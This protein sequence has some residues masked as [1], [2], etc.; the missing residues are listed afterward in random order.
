VC[1]AL[2]LVAAGA[3]AATPEEM[4][5]R[6]N[7]AYERGEYEQAAEDYRAVLRYRI[8]DPVVEYNLGNAE[9]KL[10][11]LGRAIL[12][13]ERARRLDPTDPEIEANLSFARASCVDRVELPA[14]AAPIEWLVRVQNR[15]GPA[16]QAWIV[17]VLVWLAAGVI[18]AGLARPGA[19]SAAHGWALA[20]V[21]AAIALGAFSWS[22]TRGR[23][24]GHRA[25]VVIEDVVEILAGP[26]PG[27]PALFTVHEGLALEIV[28][29]RQEWLQVALP[30]GLNGWVPRAAVEVV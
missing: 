1:A 29:D 10:G 20:L 16:R 14:Q 13:Y 30:N 12:H 2:V 22:A 23:L 18:A 26:G 7:D 6:G 17:L 15:L 27:N 24:V 4:F 28:G 9:F 8:H 19:F 3:L 21:V 25:A 11:N 5:E